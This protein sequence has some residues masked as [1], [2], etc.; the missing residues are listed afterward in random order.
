MSDESIVMSSFNI[1]ELYLPHPMQ[2][3]LSR[4]D[5]SDQLNNVIGGGILGSANK[6]LNA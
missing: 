5:A 6:D 3:G 2:C 1:D 4:S